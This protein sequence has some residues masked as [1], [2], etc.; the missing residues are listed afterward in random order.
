VKI[1][2][3]FDDAAID[4]ASHFVVVPLIND[5]NSTVDL[6]ESCALANEFARAFMQQIISSLICQPQ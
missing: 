4:V 6:H 3:R 1:Q 2:R 5:T